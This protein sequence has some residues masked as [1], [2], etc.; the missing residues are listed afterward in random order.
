MGALKW[1]RSEFK[2]TKQPLTKQIFK[3]W[4]KGE[5]RNVIE[6]KLKEIPARWFF[7]RSRAKRM[8]FKEARFATRPG[9]AF[10]RAVSE[11]LGQFPLLLRKLGIL[12]K[13]K[14]YKDLYSANG[15]MALVV[16]PRAVAQHEFKVFL[17]EKL[18]NFADLRPFDRLSSHV[19]PALSS[20]AEQLFFKAIKKGDQYLHETGQ[21]IILG[22][23]AEYGWR[24]KGGKGH[25]YCGYA[26]KD[27]KDLT[28]RGD[29]RK[30]KSEIKDV[31]AGQE[32]HLRRLD[33]HEI[34]QVSS[35]FRMT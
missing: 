7:G 9:G 5:G 3:E 23:D 20:E 1:K 19:L 2:V 26:G 22:V 17:H 27:G 31:L 32:I 8:L 34:A 33:P 25:Y 4:T 14:E 24:L 21:S 6:R 16:I 12:I 28:K 35:T 13:R 30:F 11:R 15:R 18:G 10:S 29:L